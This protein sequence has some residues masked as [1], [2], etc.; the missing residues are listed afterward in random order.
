MSNRFAVVGNPIAHS[1]SPIIHQHFA[2]E[3]QR[4]F[5]LFAINFFVMGILMQDIKYFSNAIPF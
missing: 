1:L 2:Q 3:F 4:E 5:P